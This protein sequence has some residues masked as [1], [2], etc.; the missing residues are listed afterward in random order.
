MDEQYVF[1]PVELAMLML[2]HQ[3]AK[4]IRLAAYIEV[5]SRIGN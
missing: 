4:P 3:E 2:S 5:L 1:I